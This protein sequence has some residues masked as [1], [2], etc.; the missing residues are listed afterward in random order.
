MRSTT[1]STVAMGAL[2]LLAILLHTGCG[3]KP[4][5]DATGDG[6]AVPFKPYAIQ[7][8]SKIVTYPDGLQLY[9]VKAGPGDFPING[10]HVRMHYY[11]VLDD[12][13]VFD[14]SYSR[15][16]PLAFTM[17]ASTVIDGIELAVKKLRLGSQ[18]IAIIPSTLGYGDGKGKHELPPKIPANAR[19]TF[20]LDLIGSF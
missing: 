9:V 10:T 17:G 13:T 8:S 3:R 7:D 12:G 20:H 1:K 16:E 18:A 6:A 5:A 4:E 15:G 11:G 19:L 2:L 14:Q